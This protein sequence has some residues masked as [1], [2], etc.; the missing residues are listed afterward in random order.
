MHI[1]KTAGLS[2]T[3]VL[4]ARFERSQIF[5]WHTVRR[6][7]TPRWLWY[8]FLRMNRYR[9]VRGHFTVLCEKNIMRRLMPVKPVIVTMLRDPLARVVSDYQHNIRQRHIPKDT[10]LLSYLTEPQYQ[11]LVVNL[12]TRWL[13]GSKLHHYDRQHD[14]E[15]YQPD[16]L[17]ERAKRNL[18]TLAYFGIVEYFAESLQFM[19][20]HFGWEQPTTLPE[21]NRSPK[22]FDLSTLDDQEHDAL[23]RRVALD[24]EL[25]NHALRL[26]KQRYPGVV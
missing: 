2:I 19:N 25:Y 17:L 20:D 13:A 7:P 16:Q 18:D 5:P 4:D 11:Y 21:V 6:T 10:T 3:S 23:H 9:L 8:V 12:Q 26:F 24:I 15:W 14:W 1:P 22:P